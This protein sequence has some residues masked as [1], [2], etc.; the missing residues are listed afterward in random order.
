M[1]RSGPH[2]N[3]LAVRNTLLHAFKEKINSCI[4][5]GLWR[6]ALIRA[7][8]YREA[9]ENVVLLEEQSDNYDDFDSDNKF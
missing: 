5:V 4:I 2:S 8:K 9:D 1:A 7:K 6:R 3:L